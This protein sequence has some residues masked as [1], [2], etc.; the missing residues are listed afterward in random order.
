VQDNLFYGL[1][2]RPNPPA[3]G[4]DAERKKRI[5]EALAA[6]NSTDDPD[7]D[8]IDY[9]SAGAKDMESLTARAIEV[10]SI[11]DMEADIYEFGL[12]GTIDPAEH[13]IRAGQF[14]EARKEFLKRLA[15]P[16]IAALVEAFDAE[17]YN[18][19]ATV[20]ENLLFGS[21]VG[22]TLDME[23]LAEHPY[24]LRVLDM[25]GL[26][27]DMLEAGRQVASTMCE[28]FADLPPGHEFFERFAFISHE[29][30]PEYQTLLARIARDGT[31]ALREEERTMLMSLPFKLVPARHRLGVVD[32]MKER[33]L[34]A[35][36]IFAANLPAELAGAVESFDVEKYNAAST[37]QDNIL[38]GKLAYGQAR[39]AERVGAL[40]AELVDNLGL[41][42]TAI[43][44]GLGY[45]AGIAGS[46][47][48]P[49]QRQKLALA[50]SILKQPDLLVMN[51]SMTALDAASH[52]RVMDRLLEEFKG[53]GVIWALHRASLAS[54][55]GYII[56]MRSGRVVEHGTYGELEATGQA[57]KELISAE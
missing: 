26:T 29:D 10:L 23:Q 54:R 4:D 31:S 1:R 34:E 38:F 35:R 13:P 17:K 22:D 55:F 6:G 37:L 40:L 14:L 7:D 9:A 33:L 15:D 48:L 50:R 49:A 5:N 39:G 52:A 11:V 25:A 27:D 42:P 51:E 30:L 21:L 28:L 2:H 47:L 36:R 53:R 44:V 18:D 43:E 20:A 24:V 16:E 56:V 57:F 12:R 46:R 19:N 45:H 8:W 3:N 32:D 41:R